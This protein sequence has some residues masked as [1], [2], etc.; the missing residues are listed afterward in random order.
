LANAGLTKLAALLRT[1]FC[2][3]RDLQR[4]VDRQLRMWSIGVSC[5]PPRESG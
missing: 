5:R 1:G 4:I 2:R 3:P